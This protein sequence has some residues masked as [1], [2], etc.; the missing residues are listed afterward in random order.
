MFGTKTERAN[1]YE[2]HTGKCF[3]NP[4]NDQEKKKPKKRTN[5]GENK[6]KKPNRES[7]KSRLSNA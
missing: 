7:Q 1:N 3:E 6:K 2:C 4:K 5:K